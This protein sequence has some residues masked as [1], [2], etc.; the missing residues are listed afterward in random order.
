MNQL[1]A[2]KFVIYLIMILSN[3]VQWDLDLP[4]NQDKTIVTFE[5]KERNILATGADIDPLSVTVTLDGE[6]Y[7]ISGKLKDPKKLEEITRKVLGEE[8]AIYSNGELITSPVVHQVI[9]SGG[10]SIAGGYT[11]EESEELAELIRRSTE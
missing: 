4:V 9:T 10:F 5:D 8:L 7:F 3:G 6:Q 11:L 1:M 2:L